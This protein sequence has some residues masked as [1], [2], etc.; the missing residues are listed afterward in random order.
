MG[1]S[2]LLVIREA[3]KSES[4]SDDELLAAIQSGCHRSFAKLV[5]QHTDKFYRLAV[6]TLGN[7]SEA[8]DVLQTVFLKLWQQPFKYKPGK[9]KFTTWFY[10]VVLNECRDRFRKANVARSAIS[11]VT[12][13]S[14]Q[15]S[16]QD[17]L[18][19]QQ[20]V[21]MSRSQLLHAIGELA[22]AQRDAINLKVFEELSQKDVARIMGLSVKAVESLLVRAKKNLSLKMQALSL[23]QA[24]PKVW[25][26]KPPQK[27][28]RS[29]E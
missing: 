24:A 15:E 1:S 18:E 17:Q 16:A 5:E 7:E 12:F 13:Q 23:E 25:Q 28:V 8:D 22:D 11:Q 19:K 14:E 4:D 2:K 29:S 21:S 9:A 26:N 20:A 10:R 27:Y 6:N 3:Q